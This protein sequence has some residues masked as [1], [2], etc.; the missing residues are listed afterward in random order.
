MN[1]TAERTDDCQLK[2]T[3]EVDQERVEQQLRKAARRL[4]NRVAIPGFRKGKASYEMVVRRLGLPA[5]YDEA[6]EDLGQEVYT[7]ALKDQQVNPYGQGNLENF[8]MDPLV[9]HFIVP[10]MP[11]VDLGDYRSV[12]IEPEPVNITDEDVDK[13]VEQLREQKAEWEPVDR[14]L[15]AGD[16]AL[17][18]IKATMDGETVDDSD[19]NF[20]VNPAMQYPIPGFHEAV[21][22][23]AVGETRDFTLTYPAD[24]ESTE[25]A[26]KSVHFELAL[27]EVSEKVLPELND[28]FA[29]L[30]GDFESL[31]DLRDRTRRDLEH[32]AVHAA[33]HR[34]EDVALS[35]VVEGAKILFPPP[36]LER[37]LDRMI[38]EQDGYVRR[39]QNVGL[40]DY[41]KMIGQNMDDYRKSLSNTAATRIKRSLVLAEVARVEKLTASPEDIEAQAQVMVRAFSEADPEVRSFL[42]SEA[43]ESVIRRDV[44]TQKALDRLATIAQGAA[45]AIEHEE[46]EAAP[47][48]VPAESVTG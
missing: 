27:K 40:E 2:L 25:N 14:P 19:R 11:E 33:A 31:D 15:G 46:T 32:Q 16:R 12:R 47:E 3:V 13:T 48:T 17:A 41:L 5:V 30:M 23:M 44:L 18:H 42:N 7:E 10:L 38:D 34:L 21:Q 1:I 4:A 26:G 9:L 24:W 22:G 36:M 43:G 39:E 37:E 8:T 28:D 6:L 29:L 45:P 35:R 20:V